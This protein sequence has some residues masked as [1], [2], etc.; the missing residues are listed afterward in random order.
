MNL[1]TKKVSRGIAYAALGLI[2]AVGICLWVPSMI[3]Q[4]P[5]QF[6]QTNSSTPARDWSQD[7]QMKITGPFTLAS[8]G[9]VMI[10]RPASQ[11]DDPRFQS[12]IK[13]IRDADVGFGNFESLIRDELN[14]QGPLSGAMNGTKEVAPD[15]KA[16]GFKLMNRAGNHLLESSQEGLFETIRLMQ[17]AGL[18]YAGAGRDLDDARAPRFLE[19]P[20]GRIGLV[21]CSRR[22]TTDRVTQVRE[23]ARRQ[24]TA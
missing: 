18:V 3:G 17:E 19:T 6:G 13:I 10:I 12:A 8:V 16:M 7:M 22:M 2:L 21:V 24:P 14:F 1:Q 23:R 4:G 20:K 15:L 11:I 9:D 5:G